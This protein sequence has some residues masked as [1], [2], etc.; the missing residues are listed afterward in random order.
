MTQGM[1]VQWVRW[2]DVPSH[3]PIVPH[4]HTT[5]HQPLP[6]QGANTY[7][8]TNKDKIQIQNHPIVPHA[9]TTTPSLI[10]VEGSAQVKTSI[11]I[12]MCNDTQI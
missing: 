9:H 4:A 5:N 6:D 7:T 12:H 1:I 3:D 10:K 11:H 8:N 2:D